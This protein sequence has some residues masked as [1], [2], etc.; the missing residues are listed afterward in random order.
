MQVAKGCFDSDRIA[1]L[2]LLSGRR[3]V[4]SFSQRLFAATFLYLLENLP[5]V[6]SDCHSTSSLWNVSRI[7]ETSLHRTHTGSVNSL[8]IFHRSVSDQLIAFTKVTSLEHK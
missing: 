2:D 1:N 4:P 8:N 3:T 5:A 6:T 7:G